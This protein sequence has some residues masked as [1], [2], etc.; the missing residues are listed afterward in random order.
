ML[1]NL[2]YIA[3]GLID[4]IERMDRTENIHTRWI[5]HTCVPLQLIIAIRK[6]GH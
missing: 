4:I 2:P 5:I 6:D 1:V 3:E